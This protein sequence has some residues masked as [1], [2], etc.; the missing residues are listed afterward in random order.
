[1]N[2][3]LNDT[4]EQVSDLEDRKMEIK[5]EQQKGKQIKNENSLKDLQET[6]SMPTF[7]FQGSQKEKREKGVNMILQSFFQNWIVCHNVCFSIVMLE[8]LMINA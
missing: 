3:T 2:I 4:E 7:A 5:L 8:I 6:S 1:M